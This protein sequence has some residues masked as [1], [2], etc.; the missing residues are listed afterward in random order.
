M[1][2]SA[3]LQMIEQAQLNIKDFEVI[4]S[5]FTSRNSFIFLRI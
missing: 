3:A 4:L 1:A 2:I 5:F